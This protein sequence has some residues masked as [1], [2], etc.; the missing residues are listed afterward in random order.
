[1]SWPV[2]R[3]TVVVT[4]E[5]NSDLYAVMIPAAEIIRFYYAT[6]TRAITHPRMRLAGKDGSDDFGC[7]GAHGFAPVNQAQRRP[8]DMRPMALWH[9]LRNDR[10][11]V[12]RR[13]APVRGNA[14]ARKVKILERGEYKERMMVRLH[15]KHPSGAAVGVRDRDGESAASASE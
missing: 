13:T 12:G 2:V 4:V 8:L 6:S 1:M 14:L 11:A 3:R 10:V 5:Q 15:E 7:G 9:V